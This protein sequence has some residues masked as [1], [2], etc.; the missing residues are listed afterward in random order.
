VTYGVG[1]LGSKPAKSQSLRGGARGKGPARREPR[2]TRHAV[3]LDT[4]EAACGTVSGLQVFDDLAWE[5]DGEW[6]PVCEEV[7]PFD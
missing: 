2:G 5:P 4:G 1:A 3:D 7:V 6:C